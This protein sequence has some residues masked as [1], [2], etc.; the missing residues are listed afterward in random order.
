MIA[1]MPEEGVMSKSMEYT[2]YISLVSDLFDEGRVTGNTQN[3]QKLDATKINLARIRRLDKKYEVSQSLSDLLMKAAPMDWVVF[4][5]GW[6]GDSAQCLPIINKMAEIGPN[7]SLKILLRDENMEYM[8]QYLTNGSASVPK[9]VAFDKEGKELFTWGA[10]PTKIQEMV[11]DYKEK[12][13]LEDRDAFVLNLHKWYA[14]DR[15]LSLE[16]D[17]KMLLTS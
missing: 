2:K 15:G 5:E 4:S 7:V 8:E 10:R 16:E 12:Y 1:D 9:L 11:I 17:F 6:C 3:Q 13:T 14:K